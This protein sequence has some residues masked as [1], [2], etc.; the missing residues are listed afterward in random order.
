MR[1]LILYSAVLF[2]WPVA[3][4]IKP[5]PNRTEDSAAIKQYL[6]R[7]KELSEKNTT[8][9]ISW[10]TKALAAAE[11]INYLPGMAASETELGILYVK[12]R[13]YNEALTHL[14]KAKPALQKLNDEISL[15]ILYK[16]IGDIYSARSYFRQSFDNYREAA[17]LLR[18]TGQLKL[19]NE[20]QDAMG[21][22]TLDFGQ[23][24]GALG[25]FKRS[26]AVKTSLNDE[27][28]IIATN[29]KLSKIYFSL[30]QYDSALY[31]S[32]EVQRLAKEDAEA[33]ADGAID[34]FV[35]LSFLGKLEEAAEAKKQAEKMIARQSNLANTVRLLAATS[36]YYMATKDKAMAER[37]FDSAASLVEKSRSPELAITGLTL[38]SEMSSQTEDYKT[39]FRMTR[40]LDKYKDIFRNENIE[41]ISAEIR[42]NADASL[43]EKEIEYLSLVNKLKEQELSKEELKRMALLRENILKDS[44]LASQRLLMAALETESNLRNS[45]LSKEKELSLSLSREN[46]LKQQ[47]L[48]DERRNKNMLWAGLALMTLLGGIIF[49]QFKKQQK[50]NAIINKQS[51]ELEVLNKEI[52][53]RVKNNLQVISSMLDLQSQSLNDERATALIKEAIQRVQSMAFIHQNLYQGNVVNSV[54]MNEY[55]RMLSNHLFQTYNIRTDKIRLHTSIEDMNLHTDTAIPLGMILNELISNALK[56]A[57]REKD[58]GDI[59]VTLKKQNNEMLLEVK[60]NGIGLKAGFDPDNS[61]SFGYEIIKAFA[62]KM[63]ARMNIDGSDGTDVQ[64][65][66]SRF[67]TIT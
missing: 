7:S 66:I 30:K 29:S 3:G 56:Y 42:N 38:L 15:G 19:L 27:P 11:A 12:T 1:W 49:F 44:S 10:A 31:F 55:I 61:G 39:A 21:N 48:N 64:L 65:I 67:K 13:S 43:K 24:R 53:H 51:S 26:L 52:H 33:R 6:V 8:A 20:C 36:G 40:L 41:R 57:F 25:Y 47:L 5:A 22:I 54:N 23:P 14:E 32:R 37:Y 9:A 46:N 62:Q 60:D 16:T 28:G 4:Q 35:N 58:S 2:V 50:K 45:Q 34:E 17:A 63:K 59:W 18:K